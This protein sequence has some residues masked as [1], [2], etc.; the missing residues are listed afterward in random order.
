MSAQLRIVLDQVSQ[1]V[2][3]D[4]ASASLDLAAG[5]VDTAPRDCTVGAIVPGGA[6][7][8]IAG[9]DD[10]RALSGGR[11]ELAAAWQLG[12][13]PGVGGGLIHA[14]TLMAPLVRHDRL[15]DNDQTTVTLWDLRAWEAPE[16]LSKTSV[17]WQ[18]GML[19]RAVKHAD[20]VVVPSHAIAE[21]L[22]EIATLGERIRVIA[23]APPRGFAAPVDD[24][25][26]RRTLGLP[27]RFAVVVG[28]PAAMTPA[29]RAVA[30]AGL[31]AV[32]LDAV[33][34]AEPAIAD[35]A[36]AAGL[37]EGR[38]HVR[39]ALE[40]RDRAA[41]LAGAEGVLAPGAV[42][43]WPWRVV[44]AMALGAAVIAVDSGVHRDVIAD[45]G[46]LA[47]AE[48][49]ADA[50]AAAFA[51]RTERLRVLSADRG[52]AFSWSSTAERVWALHAE[53]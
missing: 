10:V 47:S 20:A 45:G 48:D 44:E 27:E 40:E 35:A 29:F 16:L 2:D 1:I 32:V 19:R 38:A 17:A 8:D 41:V 23:G 39:G 52:R 12:F 15:H 5:L 7:V 34:G 49:F 13:A 31:D 22:A 51:D 26:R 3:P 14:P 30:T 33:E 9:L 21:R 11:R 25:G 43:A 6:E 36:A 37:A 50:A 53:L 4:L 46:L 24:V 28:D 18:R 42:A